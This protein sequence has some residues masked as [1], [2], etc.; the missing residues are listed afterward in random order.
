MTPP[1]CTQ[2]S[3]HHLLT[4]KQTSYYSSPSIP[5]CNVPRPSAVS[6]EV[7]SHCCYRVT[8]N[9]GLKNIKEEPPFMSSFSQM[10]SLRWGV[11]G[12]PSR[13]HITKE[14]FQKYFCQ[15]Y[16]QINY[17]YISVNNQIFKFHLKYLKILTANI[18]IIH[19]M[20]IY[21]YHYYCNA[22]NNNYFNPTHVLPTLIIF[23]WSTILKTS[24]SSKI[25]LR[26]NKPFTFKNSLTYLLSKRTYNIYY[27][28]I[29]ASFYTEFDWKYCAIFI[30]KN[31]TKVY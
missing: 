8:G 28:K 29:A 17:A 6:S 16:I 23:I 3:P 22:Y 31:N 12:I 13:E 20:M 2:L 18:T 25:F 1:Y 27:L 4:Q 10:R 21:L 14:L 9:L 11:I 15:F 5:C 26:K 19:S 30:K 24:V 7:K